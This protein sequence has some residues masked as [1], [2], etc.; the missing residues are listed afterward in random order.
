MEQKRIAVVE[1][2]ISKVRDIETACASALK[3]TR[4]SL[5]Q[6]PCCACAFVTS[7]FSPISFFG[8]ILQG[9]ARKAQEKAKEHEAWEA[10]VE[11][12]LAEKSMLAQQLIRKIEQMVPASC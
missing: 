6:S 8:T 5:T 1:A 2:Y 10:A 4:D 12:K 11:S 3:V 9:L 7:R